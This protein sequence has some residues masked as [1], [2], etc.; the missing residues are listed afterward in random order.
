MQNPRVQTLIETIELTQNLMV[1]YVKLLKDADPKKVFS[2]EGI[3][4][5]S[6]YW[7]VAHLAWAENMLILDGTYGESVKL[8]WLDQFKFGAEHQID[9]KV[10][11]AE[12]KTTA[13]DIHQ[14]AIAHL[15]SLKDEDLDKPNALQFGFG[16][17]PTNKVV[18]MHFI[19]H[20]GT[21]I[22]HLSC[23]C[24]LHGVKAV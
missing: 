6:L 14:K 7:L 3:D 22:G 15:N 19:R 5:N 16:Q 23:L 13:K 20:L 17:D 12:L 24:K 8:P 11:F 4:L 9:E 1:F 21:H 10:S 2:I 18:I